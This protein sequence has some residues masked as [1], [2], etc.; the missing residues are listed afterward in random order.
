MGRSLGITTL[1]GNLLVAIPGGADDL[2]ME[3]GEFPVERVPPTLGHI[4]TWVPSSL[5]M[6]TW[7]GVTSLFCWSVRKGQFPDSGLGLFVVVVGGGAGSHYIV[8]PGLELTVFP[9]YTE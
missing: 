5:C 6:H 2:V 3:H 1:I 4:A 8:Q 7:E 9:Q